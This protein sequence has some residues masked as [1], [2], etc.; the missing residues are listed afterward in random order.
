MK[1]ITLS[2][3]CALLLGGCTTISPQ[4]AATAHFGTVP[5]DYETQIKN[6]MA[7]QLK[8]P[9]SAM[10][11]FTPPRRGYWQDGMIYGGK[12]H[13]GYIAVIG[14]N[15]KNSFGGYTGE[16]VRYLCIEHGRVVGDATS[17]WGQMAGFIDDRDRWQH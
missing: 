6:F 10:Y 11:T 14:V 15:A 7:G 4:E 5:V 17:L 12:K 8:D 2:L 1:T 16:Q 3:M 13:F 9:Y